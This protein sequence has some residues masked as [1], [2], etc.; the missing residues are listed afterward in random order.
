MVH[1]IIGKIDWFYDW[2]DKDS[3]NNHFQAAVIDLWLFSFLP[4]STSD[5]PSGE[6]ENKSE[7]EGDCVKVRMKMPVKDSVH[8]GNNVQMQLFL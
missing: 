4:T 6:G 5:W 1:T 8:N 3:P 7:A 2:F